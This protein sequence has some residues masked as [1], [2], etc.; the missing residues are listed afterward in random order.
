M[1]TDEDIAC[2][3]AIYAA[4]EAGKSAPEIAAAHRRAGAREGRET[5]REDAWRA[6]WTAEPVPEY[7]VEREHLNAFQYGKDCAMAAIR[8]IPLDPTSTVS[9]GPLA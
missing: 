3:N 2:A 5:M 9:P 4:Y 8:T 7:P 6:A 1:I